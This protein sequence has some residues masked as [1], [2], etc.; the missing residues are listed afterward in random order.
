MLGAKP[1]SA[2][3]NPGY[4]L[5]AATAG[6]M[7]ACA[8]ATS[9][10]A[11]ASAARGLELWSRTLRAG[12]APPFCERARATAAAGGMPAGVSAGP[13]LGAPSG[14]PTPPEAAGGPAGA[15][16]VAARPPQAEAGAFASY[17]STG[18]HA[19]AQVTIAD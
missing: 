7:W 9:R 2:N 11:V 6:M 16:T 14:P 12:A 19:A 17:R 1:D 10:I 3:A 4:N 15:A 18:G 13:S 5:A 8:F